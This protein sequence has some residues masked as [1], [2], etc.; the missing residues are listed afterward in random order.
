MHGQHVGLQDSQAD[1]R[2][3][4][5]R[6][7]RQPRVKAGIDCER[8]AAVL[9]QRVSIGSGFRHQFG[10]DVTIRSGTIVEY[11]RLAQGLSEAGGERTHHRIRST[12]GRKRDDRREQ[13][14]MDK[15]GLQH[16]QQQKATTAK[17]SYDTRK[18]SEDI[19][20]GTRCAGVGYSPVATRAQRQPISES[21]RAP[22]MQ[23]WSAPTRSAQL[24]RDD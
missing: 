6:I 1:R 16:Q 21:S 13:A 17:H 10:T 11:E 12:A 20:D 7:V 24:P 2:E 14:S 8:P 3:V 9:E 4:A 23:A 18:S 15:A 22:H 5:Q 19:Y